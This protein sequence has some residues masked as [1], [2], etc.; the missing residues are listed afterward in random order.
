MKYKEGSPLINE[1]VKSELRHRQCYCGKMLEIKVDLDKEGWINQVSIGD[2]TDRSLMMPKTGTRA[3]LLE[4]VM[5]V[6]K[7]C[8]RRV[9]VGTFKA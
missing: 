7:A 9:Q 1:T 3:G 6:C 4:R 8:K 5:T 2:D